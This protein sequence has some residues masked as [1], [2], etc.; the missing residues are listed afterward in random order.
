MPK[1]KTHRGGAKRISKTGTGKLRRFKA[2]RRHMLESK[3]PERK[4]DLRGSVILSQ[5]DTKR[6]AQLLTY[7]K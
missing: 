3:S 2:Y 1:M 4:R 7:I 5:G 6:V